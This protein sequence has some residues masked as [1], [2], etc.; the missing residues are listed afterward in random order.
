MHEAKEQI[1]CKERPPH[2]PP[3]RAAPKHDSN[4]FISRANILLVMKCDWSTLQ[5]TECTI[6]IVMSLPSKLRNTKH[7]TMTQHV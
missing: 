2:S 5:T 4:Q 1:T 7:C 3:G 6:S